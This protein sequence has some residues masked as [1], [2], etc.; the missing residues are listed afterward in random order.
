M[1][2]S[3][4]TVPLMTHVDTQKQIH[5]RIQSFVNELGGLVRQAALEACQEALGGVAAPKRRGRPRKTKKAPARRKAVKRKAKKTGKR[6][7]RSGAQV[8]AI[9]VRVLAHVKKKP[10][11]S[12]T[13]IS[14]ALRRTPKDLQLPI[15]KLIADKKLRTTGQRRGTKYFAAGRGAGKKKVA[16]KRATKKATKRATKKRVAKRAVRRKARRAGKK[17]ATKK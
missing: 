10:G 6:A 5:D 8:E 12:V 14:K 1:Q 11:Q 7:K 15:R 9:S 4:G 2:A 17:A 13:E 3:F 16:K